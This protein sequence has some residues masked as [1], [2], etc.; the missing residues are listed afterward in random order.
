MPTAPGLDVNFKPETGKFDDFQGGA[1]LA[2]NTL[3]AKAKCRAGPLYPYTLSLQRLKTAGF[4]MSFVPSASEN[5]NS[6]SV[7]YGYFPY[8][9]IGN[10]ISGTTPSLAFDGQS[11]GTSQ[12]TQG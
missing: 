3:L 10:S 2:A 7:V 8:S 9:S 11:I 6:G 1:D 12:I 4:S 5:D